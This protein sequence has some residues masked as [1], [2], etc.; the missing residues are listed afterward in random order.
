MSY[1]ASVL[2]LDRLAMRALK[3]TD[4]YSIHR[5]VYSLFPDVRTDEEKASS[6]PSGFLFADKGGDC[7][8]RT[9][10]M[11]SD[12]EPSKAVNDAYG[13]VVSKSIDDDF[14][15][16]DLYRFQVIMNPT[17]RNNES[18]KLIPV[19]GREA[20]GQWF[21]ERAE[22]SWGFSV[23]QASLDVRTVHVLRFNA[24]NNRQVTIAQAEV[25]G[26]LRVTDRAQFIK[27]FA[28]GIG[29]GRSFGCGLLQIS[30]L[31]E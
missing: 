10:L 18:K 8:G 20:I 7:D 15:K 13:D 14:L 19:K 23:F 16:H 9:I 4:P 29:R 30:P 17:R 6:V 27:S 25:H 5:A 28:S 12:R 24:Q 1:Y 31:A 22:A 3:I 26:V 21:Q 2:R 11:L